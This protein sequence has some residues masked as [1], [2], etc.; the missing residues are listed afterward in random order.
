MLELYWFAYAVMNGQGEKIKYF[1]IL[2]VVL[3]WFGYFFVKEYLDYSNENETRKNKSFDWNWNCKW[4]KNEQ[5][6]I[7]TGTIISPIIKLEK[8]LKGRSNEQIHIEMLQERSKM[9]DWKY[10][11]L[12][13]WS[14]TSVTNFV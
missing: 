12:L 10:M 6:L 11:C 14:K 4:D 7:E 13:L 2:N 8:N 3:Y 1:K 5:T 9:I